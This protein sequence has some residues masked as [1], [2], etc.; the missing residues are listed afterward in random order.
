M[1]NILSTEL[2]TALTVIAITEGTTGKSHIQLR[3]TRPNSLRVMLYLE[4]YLDTSDHLLDE[5]S[6]DVKDEQLDFTKVT[7]KYLP[8]SDRTSWFPPPRRQGS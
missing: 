1:N 2:A 7:A 6:A 3:Q 5:F 4:M 8:I